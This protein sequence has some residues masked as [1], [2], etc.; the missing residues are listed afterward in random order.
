MDILSLFPAWLIEHGAAFI[1]VLPLLLGAI[2]AV[3]P[4]RSLAWWT[5]FIVTVIVTIT[6]FGLVLNMISEG[7]S[8]IHI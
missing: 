7:L 1:I 6:S 8:L 5:A 4:S 3:L 2:T